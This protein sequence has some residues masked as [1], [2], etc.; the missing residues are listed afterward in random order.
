MWLDVREAFGDQVTYEAGEIRWQ[1]DVLRN[2]LA[3]AAAAGRAGERV[4][5]GRLTPD[6][7]AAAASSGVAL[8][9]PGQLALDTAALGRTLSASGVSRADLEL[10]PHA[11]RY[12]DR[13]ASANGLLLFGKSVA[14]GELGLL[15]SQA[16]SGY[17]LETVLKR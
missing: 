14:D 5:L 15:V 1:G 3:S 17:N 6:A 11:W 10:I 13:V 16:G 12:P 4:E 2:K 7:R 9:T 8:D